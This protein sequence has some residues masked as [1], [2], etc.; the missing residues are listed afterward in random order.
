MDNLNN[1]NNMNN[2]NNVNNMENYEAV[3]WNDKVAYINQALYGV[4]Q[5]YSYLFISPEIKG[6][7][8]DNEIMFEVPLDNQIRIKMND[9]AY[10]RM[11]LAMLYDN[12]GILIPSC[13]GRDFLGNAWIKMQCVAQNPA[14]G[15]LEAKTEAILWI[16]H[17]N[18]EPQDD[19]IEYV[20][21]I[22]KVSLVP[23]NNWCNVPN[24]WVPQQV[25]PRIDWMPT[26]ATVP[27]QDETPIDWM[28]TGATVP[29]QVET[30]I[31]WMP[32]EATVPQQVKTPI[33]WMPTEATVPH[34]VETSIDWMPTEAT[35]RQQVGP[36]I[37]WMPTDATVPGMDLWDS[38]FNL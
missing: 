33:D 26:E 4:G 12:S 30:P 13:S 11:V 22:R 10:T 18:L 6:V 15:L 9:Q 14:S 31:D 29:Q 3:K 35:V 37:D 24:G 8:S 5:A 27:Q 38:S 17:P 34:Q 25:E 23:Y 32:T 2:M 36:L 16:L 28:P 19:P 20:R 7:E 21:S 1:M